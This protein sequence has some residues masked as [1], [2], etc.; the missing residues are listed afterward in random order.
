MSKIQPF[1]LR[2]VAHDINFSNMKPEEKKF[3][4]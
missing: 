2:N 3:N 1:Y 4:K